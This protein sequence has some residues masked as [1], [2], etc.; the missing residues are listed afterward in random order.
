MYLK[1]GVEMGKRPW[2]GFVHTMSNDRISF[3]VQSMSSLCVKM[4]LPEASN[5]EGSLTTSGA[6]MSE[7]SLGRAS[8]R[9]MCLIDVRKCGWNSG[10]VWMVVCAVAS[11][12]CVVGVWCGEVE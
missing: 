1:P 8:C 3:L 4:G 6:Y 2:S 7:K 5:T 12:L 10:N 9:E 11:I